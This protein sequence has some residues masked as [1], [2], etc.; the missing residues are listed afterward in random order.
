MLTKHAKEELWK[1][2]PEL[3]TKRLFLV[4]LTE[5]NI[6]ELLKIWG[7]PIIAKHN[8][9]PPMDE[10]EIKNSLKFNEDEFSDLRGIRWGV[11]L[12]SNGQ[13]IG[14]AGYNRWETVISNKAMLG[15][16]VRQEYWNQG[17]SSEASNRIIDYGFNQMK[18]H[19]IEAETSPEN[20]SAQKVLEKLG[21][22]FEGTLRDAYFWKSQ[23]RS[24]RLY[25]LLEYEWLANIN[26]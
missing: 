18:L 2:F 10:V 6:P 17:I 7:D 9:F 16:D 5:K 11:R 1:V 14:T 19:R 26:G 8:G 22:T 15:A 24:M 20:Y 23:Y 25:S 3:E 4:R 21:F 13:I 12:K